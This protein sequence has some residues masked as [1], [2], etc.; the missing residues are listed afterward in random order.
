MNRQ[1]FFILI[2]L[3]FGGVLTDFIFN[4][5]LKIVWIAIYGSVY[6]TIASGLYSYLHERFG[7][8]FALRA[9]SAFLAGCLIAHL[10]FAGHREMRVY[11]MSLI[12]DSGIILQSPELSQTLYISSDQVLKVLGKLDMKAVIPVSIQVTKDYGCIFSFKVAT[13]AGIDV[14]NDSGSNWVWRQDGSRTAPVGGFS[15]LNEENARRF[16]CTIAWF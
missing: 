9:G 1:A 15:G 8:L 14:M 2:G 7:T 13:V 4:G 10:L 16:W 12:S 5:L 11:S 3:F 6:L